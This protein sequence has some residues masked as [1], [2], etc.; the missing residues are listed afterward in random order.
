MDRVPLLGMAR[1]ST[2]DTLLRSFA[3]VR[4][5]RGASQMSVDVLE[6]Q[7]GPD[8]QYLGLVQQVGARLGGPLGG[9]VLGG[10]PGLGR[11]LD[12]LLPDEVHAAI[13]RRY[14]GRTRGALHRLRL[15]LGK[16]L[17]KGLHGADCRSPS[18]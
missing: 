18:R 2:W 15:Q 4:N 6:I 13:E 16:E 3:L 7:A 8:H 10:H 17:V 9:L 14:G 5:S 12:D 11:L 1:R